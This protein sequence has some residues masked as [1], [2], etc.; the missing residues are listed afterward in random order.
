MYMYMYRHDC[1][2]LICVVMLIETVV[3]VDVFACV[4]GV[5]SHRNRLMNI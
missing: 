5:R 2:I 3:A 4:V 1:F